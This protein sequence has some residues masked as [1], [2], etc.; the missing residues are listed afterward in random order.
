[1]RFMRQA[2]ALQLAIALP[3]VFG[4]RLALDIRSAMSAELHVEAN[5]SD[6][7][8]AGHDHTLCALV[9]STPLS[10]AAP[11]PQLG[12]SAPP[13]FAAPLLASECDPQA[14][15]H[16]TRARAPPGIIPFA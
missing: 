14:Q 1:M 10:D 5:H 3:T 8:A 9:F 13:V 7:C 6:V 4:A 16:P 11:A 15:V 2:V 12:L